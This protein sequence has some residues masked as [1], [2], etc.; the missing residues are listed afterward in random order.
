ME[1]IQNNRILVG[2]AVFIV[3]SVIVVF[4]YKYV[5]KLL[6]KR[7]RKTKS[8][9]DDF[10]IDVLRMPFL[11]L[12]IWGMFRIFSQTIFFD[13]SYFATMNHVL[14]LLFIV[15]VGWILIKL[16]SV[17]FYYLEHKLDITA[18]DSYHARS[19]LTKLKIFE[20]MITVLII[21]VTVAVCLM[22]FDKIR[23][24]GISILTSAGIAGIIVGFAAQKSLGTV[25]AGIQLAITQPV[26]LNDVVVINGEQGTIEEIKLTY[27]VVKLWDERRA[28]LPVTYFLETPFENWTRSTSE[29]TGTVYLY[30][31]YT[32]PLKPLRDK[33]M[34]LIENHPAWDRRNANIQVTNMK[35]GSIEVRVLV[36]SKNS[37]DSSD[38]KVFLREELV[39]FI[40]QNYPTCFVKQRS[41]AE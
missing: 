40:Q 5:V 37:S 34:Q 2:F 24:V 18:D 6:A 22:T 21:I 29:I 3:A 17:L 36:T 15:T 31:D 10:I 20:R 30:V 7:A 41:L 39:S 28:I 8:K 25:M 27:I 12:L 4:I 9:V 11:L 32:L 38:L 26:R 33:F 23:T 16:T 35:E 13:K 1:W 19:S 14:T